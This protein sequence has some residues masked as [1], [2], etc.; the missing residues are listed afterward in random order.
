MLSSSGYTTYVKWLTHTLIP[1]IAQ[2]QR[3]PVLPCSILREIFLHLDPTVPNDIRD[4][5]HLGLHPNSLQI[6]KHI[7]PPNPDDTWDSSASYALAASAR[8]SRT[9]S[10]IVLDVLYRNLYNPMRLLAILP[11]FQ[12][13]GDTYVRC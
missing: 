6:F 3:I 2:H 9:F 1:Q 8:V 10:D 5:S 7:E 4:A 11:E 12:K 13:V